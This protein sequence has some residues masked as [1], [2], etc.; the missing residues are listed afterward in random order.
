ML[1]GHSPC[2]PRYTGSGEAGWA[3]EADP[4]LERQQAHRKA[5]L[6]LLP[7]LLSKLLK[8]EASQLYNNRLVNFVLH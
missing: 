8:V 6:G 1:R 3:P 5:R 4:N 7:F 2:L